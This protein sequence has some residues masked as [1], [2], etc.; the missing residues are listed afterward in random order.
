MCV[1]LCGSEKSFGGERLEA[2][3]I[4]LQVVAAGSGFDAKFAL[5]VAEGFE[6]RGG[7]GGAKCDVSAGDA[8]ATGVMHNSGNGAGGFGAQKG[9]K[10]AKIEGKKGGTR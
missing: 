2:G 8:C 5:A 3:Q 10:K 7:T 9:G 1:G 6:E 4:D